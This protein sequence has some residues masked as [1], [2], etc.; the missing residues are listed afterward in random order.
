MHVW[1]SKLFLGPVSFIDV[2][3]SVMRSINSLSTPS[4]KA[5]YRAITIPGA[6][7][8]C[9]GEAS[10]SVP[11]CFGEPGENYGWILSTGAILQSKS[12]NT[13]PLIRLKVAWKQCAVW[14][15]NYQYAIA[16]EKVARHADEDSSGSISTSSW[17][18][19]DYD[20]RGR[21]YTSHCGEG[22]SKGHGT[23]CQ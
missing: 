3:P 13:D 2:L 9:W 6:F 19:G 4:G 7:T 23:V 8:C 17:T 12:Q 10:P 5:E 20:Q 16:A 18:A 14:S 15:V 21:A 1:E 11:Q 22:H